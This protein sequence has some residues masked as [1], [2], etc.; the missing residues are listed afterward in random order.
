MVGDL[1][2]WKVAFPEVQGTLAQGKQTPL[3]STFLGSLQLRD[4]LERFHTE[5]E[6]FLPS[7]DKGKLISPGP[8]PLPFLPTQ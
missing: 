8:E 2:G 1:S 5:Q 6:Q 4:S 7:G 3:C